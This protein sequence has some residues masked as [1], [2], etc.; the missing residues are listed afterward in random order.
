MQ[1]SPV[2]KKKRKVLTSERRMRLCGILAERS[3][4]IIVRTYRANDQKAIEQQDRI[5]KRLRALCA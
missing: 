1:S 4:M 2:V 3:R 5:Y